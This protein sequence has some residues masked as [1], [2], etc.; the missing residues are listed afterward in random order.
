MKELIINGIWMLV[1]VIT[2]LFVLFKGGRG[3]GTEAVLYS[4]AFL[5][6][7]LPLMLILFR[8]LAKSGFPVLGG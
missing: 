2:I 5:L 8:I 3:D 1:S 6:L 7:T 4:L